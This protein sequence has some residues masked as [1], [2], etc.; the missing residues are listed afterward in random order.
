M[1]EN[2]VGVGIAGANLPVRRRAKVFREEI[3]SETRERHL[4]CPP[5]VFPGTAVNA[6]LITGL[7]GPTGLA[8]GAVPE[9]SPWSTMACGGVVLLGIMLRNK[10]RIPSGQR[11]RVWRFARL[12]SP[13]RTSALRKLQGHANL[14]TRAGRS[15]DKP[16]RGRTLIDRADSQIA[17]D[18]ER[19]STAQGC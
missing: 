9:P 16:S 8:V 10:H 1:E 7:N 4:T 12:R 11:Y 3:E 5:N 17:E 18:P 15:E 19:V 14:N 2:E 6:S 13:G